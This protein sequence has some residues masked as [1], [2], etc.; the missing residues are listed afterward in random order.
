MNFYGKYASDVQEN[1][2]S[3]CELDSHADTSVAGRNFPLISEPMRMVT[4]HGYSPDL[5]PL[6]KIPVASAA[7]V[8]LHWPTAPVLR[9][10]HGALSDLSKSDEVQWYHCG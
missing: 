8:W 3:T 10:S 6:P 7:T 4:V 1:F 5:P 2:L 9:E